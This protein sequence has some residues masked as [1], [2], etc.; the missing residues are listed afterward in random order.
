LQLQQAHK[1]FTIYSALHERN[2][3]TVFGL[4][5]SNGIEPILIK[6]WAAARLYPDLGL[7][8][9]GDI[10]LCIP[11]HQ[12]ASALHLLEG[13]ELNECSVDLVH[14]EVTEIGGQT[15]E[16]LYVRSS[17]VGLDDVEVRIPSA[18]DHLWILCLHFL[19]HGGRIPLGLCDVAVALESRPQNFNWDLCLGG[20]SKKTHWIASTLA[21]AN[22]LLEASLND[23]PFAK[24]TDV[25]KWLPDYVLRQWRSPYATFLPTKFAS[26]LRKYLR[27]PTRLWS[28]LRDR[29]PNR[30]EATMAMRAPLN[31]VPRLSLQVG[32]CLLRAKKLVDEAVGSTA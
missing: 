28:D 30:I 26:D 21:L 1:L 19:K 8:P 9:Y 13:P 17:L 4:F 24:E 31:G 2:I 10:D 3:K 15:F 25:P 16:D 11:R 27:N 29:W 18:E 14:E 6:G 22:Q 12:Y 32:N 20:S 5:R 23:T 7:R